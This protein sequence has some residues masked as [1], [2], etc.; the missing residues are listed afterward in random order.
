MITNYHLSLQYSSIIINHLQL[1][2][3]YW[4]NQIYIAGS[5]SLSQETYPCQQDHFHF[6]D[7]PIHASTITFNA[8]YVRL[9]R[10]EI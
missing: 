6:L 4:S 1:L 9:Q 3:C 5:L 10:A 7:R 2:G 8:E